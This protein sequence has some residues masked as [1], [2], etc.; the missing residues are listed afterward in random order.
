[1][2]ILQLAWEQFRRNARILGDI[3]GHI[4]AGVFY[5]TIMLPFGLIARASGDPL[6][7]KG[8]PGWMN[9]PPVD[10]DLEAARRQG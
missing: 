10:H 5:F 8:A 6:R 3:Q 7:L 2:S 1:V 9:R 4:A